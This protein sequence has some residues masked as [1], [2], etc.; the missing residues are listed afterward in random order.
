MT[1]LTQFV[2]PFIEITFIN[3][4]L[5]G[6]NALIIA[7]ACNHLPP[8]LRKKAVWYGTIAAVVM[9]ILL[10]AAAVVLL[11]IAYLQAIGAGLL[12]YIAM[13]ML[14]PESNAKQVKTASALM[15]AIKVILLADLIMSLDNVLAVA[16]IANGN[17]TLLLIGIGMSLPLI[18]WGSHFVLHLIQSYPVLIYIGAAILAYT[19]GN[20]LIGDPKIEIWL[21]YTH[22]SYI[23]VIPLMFILMTMAAGIWFKRKQP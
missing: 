9:R 19:A 4:I 12:L 7:M 17:F 6:D 23:W 14:I 21:Q 13:K 20:M 8:P 3:L 5:S 11:Q 2:V 15:P 16:A 18:I 10:T 22:D 1:A